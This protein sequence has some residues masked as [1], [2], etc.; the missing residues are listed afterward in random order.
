LDSD[1]DRII[2]EFYDFLEGLVLKEILFF[3]KIGF[4]SFCPPTVS[5]ANAQ[6]RIKLSPHGKK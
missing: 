1:N 3:Q 6:Q 5:T 4:L 2:T